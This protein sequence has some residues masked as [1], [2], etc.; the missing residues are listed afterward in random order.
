MGFL[1][2]LL[3]GSTKQVVRTT[4]DRPYRIVDPTIGFLNLQGASGMVLAHPDRNGLGSLFGQVRES[5][6]EVPRCDVLFI[7]TRSS[8]TVQLLATRSRFAG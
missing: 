1:S 7:T 8:A 4:A 5:T 2:K 3:S 6:S